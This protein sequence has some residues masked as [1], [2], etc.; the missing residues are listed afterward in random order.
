M[1]KLDPEILA[2]RIGHIGQHLLGLFHSHGVVDTHLRAPISWSAVISGI[3]GASRISSVFGLKVRPKTATALPRRTPA[4]ADDTFRAIARFRVSLTASAASR[5]R[6][7]TWWSWAVLMSARTS[8][9]KHEP[10]NPGPACRNFD[11]IL[12]SSPMPWAT[13]WT[14]EPSFSQR[15][16][17]SLMNV[18]L[19]ARNAL[20]AYLM[21]SAVLRPV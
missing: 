11:P 14:S 16:A 18:I 3:D 7:G 20:A 9:G 4:K 1:A 21:S 8:L 12:L 5:I 13:S 10:P 15:S 19:V 17:I 2:H 6:I